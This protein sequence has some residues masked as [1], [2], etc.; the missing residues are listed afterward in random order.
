MSDYDILALSDAAEEVSFMN[1]EV[2]YEQGDEECHR[3]CVVLKGEASCYLKDA[4]GTEREV[5]RLKA[6]DH[7]VEDP[8]N[9]AETT[10]IRAVGAGRR[11]L[12]LLRVEADVFLRLA[13]SILSVAGTAPFESIAGAV[14]LTSNPTPDISAAQQA[15][16]QKDDR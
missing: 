4:A 7:F 1:N 9:A 5:A 14:E 2:A 15:S 6:G 10:N 8:A 3:L 16:W 12:I 11:A 13:G